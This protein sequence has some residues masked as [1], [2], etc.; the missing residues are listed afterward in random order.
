M[1]SVWG[2]AACNQWKPPLEAIRKLAV[3]TLV[4]AGKRDQMTPLKAGRAVAA[5]I[6][7]AQLKV[8]DCG[9][10]LMAEAPRETL[11]ALR[12]FLGGS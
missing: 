4:L 2:L 7:G 3:P 6:P 5:E 12:D 8:L 10:A 1:Q 9:H 11:A